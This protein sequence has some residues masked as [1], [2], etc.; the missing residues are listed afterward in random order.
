MPR[1]NPNPTQT[2][3]VHKGRPKGVPN[4]MTQDVRQCILDAADKL[5]GCDRIVKWAN[6][7]PEA[8]KAFWSQIYVRVLPKD[9]NIG[10]QADNPLNV[11]IKVTFVSPGGN[12]SRDPISN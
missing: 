11:G 5:G 12:G 7:S 1:G 2:V 9:I 3:P 4:K 8:E 10:G 6:S